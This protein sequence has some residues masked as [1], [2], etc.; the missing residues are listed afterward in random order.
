MND[1][2][3]FVIPLEVVEKVTGLKAWKGARDTVRFEDMSNESLK[4]T[5]DIL[6]LHQSPYI[7]RALTEIERRIERGVWLD[8]ED[9]PTPSEELPWWLK[10]WPF[11]LLWKQ[12]R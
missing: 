4:F 8:I 2:L 11:R 3:G 12:G 1:N 6:E 5:L 10:I 9:S 7:A